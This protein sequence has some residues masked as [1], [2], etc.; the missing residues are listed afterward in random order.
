LEVG[1]GKLGFDFDRAAEI[2]D[3]RVK[4]PDFESDPRFLDETGRRS[5]A[6]GARIPSEREQRNQAKGLEW[7]RRHG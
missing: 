4:L 2:S 7:R 1:F 5:L 6:Q 3:R